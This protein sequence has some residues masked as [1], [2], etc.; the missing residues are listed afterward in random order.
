M[1]ACRNNAETI[2]SGIVPC[3]EFNVIESFKKGLLNKL[4][5]E[6]VNTH[7]H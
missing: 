6:A 1:H 2:T 4:F 5:L 7:C 3:Q